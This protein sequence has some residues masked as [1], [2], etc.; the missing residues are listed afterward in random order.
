L[1]DQFLRLFI[2]ALF[3]YV[4][5]NQSRLQLFSSSSSSYYFSYSSVAAGV[6]Q[7]LAFLSKDCDS[8]THAKACDSYQ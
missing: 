2:V 7:V 8:L 5:V 1:L 6:V 4:R 3:I